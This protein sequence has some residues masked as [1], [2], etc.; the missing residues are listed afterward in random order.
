V[1]PKEQEKDVEI[2]HNIDQDTMCEILI[3]PLVGLSM[4][5]TLKIIGYIKNQKVIVLDD[6]G[7]TH[8]F[9]DKILVKH[10]NCFVYP[11]TIFKY[12]L[13]MRGIIDCLRKCYNLKLSTKDYNLSSP[14]MSF[15]LEE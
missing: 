2:L 13:Q 10:L 9:V 3:H 12:L 15:L 6:S 14:C 1:N 7:S 11:I 5:Q 8:N 4:S